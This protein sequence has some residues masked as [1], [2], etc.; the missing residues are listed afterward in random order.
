MI[1]SE[2]IYRNT[3]IS[4]AKIS[5]QQLLALKDSKVQPIDGLSIPNITVPPHLIS[6]KRTTEAC[7]TLSINIRQLF[8]SLTVDNISKV[9]EQLRNIIIKAQN[10][11]MIEE[12]AQEILS[13]FVISEQNIK[14]YMH[15]LNSVSAAC[16]LIPCK[17]ETIGQNTGSVSPTIGNCFLKK[18][19]D[20]IFNSI[21]EANIR[22]IAELDQDDMDELDKYNRQRE[23]INN[24]VTTIC[25]LYEQRYTSNIKLTSMH[26]CPLLNTIMTSYKKNQDKMKEMGNPNIEDCTDENEYEILR[27]MCT[28]YAEQLYIFMNREAREF[29]KDAEITKGQTLK[30]M[31]D[32]FKTEVI[33]TLTEEFIISKCDSIVY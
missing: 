28:L 23:K 21:Q 20:M 10:I 26:L 22:S 29:V 27:K 11:E 31:I 3:Q 9:K 13:N 32:R 33:P 17:Q 24:L 4:T 12:I 6:R 2:P 25:Y 19:R 15:L 16:V 14:N 1:N 7:D 5:V 30:N 18:C 8:N